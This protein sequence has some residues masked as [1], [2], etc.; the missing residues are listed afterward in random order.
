MKPLHLSNATGRDSRVSMAGLGKRRRIPMGTAEG[1]VRFKRYLATTDEGMGASLEARYG[2]DLAEKL[3]AGDIEVD[4]EQVG[5]AIGETAVVYLSSQGDVLYAPPAVVEVL[6]GPDGQEKERRTPLEVPP[7]VND[8][9]PVRWTGRKIPIHDVIRRFAFRRTLQ[10]K[11]VDGLTFDFLF[12]M[13]KTLHDDQVALLLGA[14]P[15]GKH[16]LIFQANGAPYQ[17]F[18]EGRVA[19]EKYK[20]LLH[21]SNLELKRPKVEEEGT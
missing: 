15:K 8:E 5:R 21:L 3:I 4:I 14:G 17:G 10:L 6:L 2:D 7:N 20:L 9:V 13:A 19:G 12:E 18:L 1:G 16:P 11:H